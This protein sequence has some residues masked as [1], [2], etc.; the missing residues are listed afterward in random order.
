MVHKPKTCGIG[1]LTWNL[2]H[3]VIASHF[4]CKLKISPLNERSQ[5]AAAATAAAAA[6]GSAFGTAISS[7]R[8]QKSLGMRH[9]K[10]ADTK[11]TCEKYTN[12]LTICAFLL[13]SHGVFLDTD[14]TL[15]SKTINKIICSMGTY[16]K[17]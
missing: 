1:T 10:R 3:R 2:K 8:S 5:T 13:H 17:L 15:I 16:A 11:Y 6:A 9:A 14:F 4:T 7:E 12:V